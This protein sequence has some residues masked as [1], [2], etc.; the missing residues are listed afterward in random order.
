MHILRFFAVDSYATGSCCERRCFCDTAGADDEGGAQKDLNKMCS[1][2]TP[3]SSCPSTEGF[4]E[5]AWNWDKVDFT[6]ANTHD[7]CA[8]FDNNDNGMAD[9][10][11][12]AS[13]G[14]SD[15]TVVDATLLLYTCRDD[16]PDRCQDA[17]IVGCQFVT[18]TNYDP[19]NGDCSENPFLSSTLE[20]LLRK[21]PEE[22]DTYSC[23]DK[24]TGHTKNSNGDTGC[25]SG[26]DPKGFD[27]IANIC[28]S[29]TDVPASAKLIDVCSYPSV[30]PNSDPSDCVVFT[31]CDMI[32]CPS[33]RCFQ[34]SCD[35]ARGRCVQDTS[36]ADAV[37]NDGVKCTLDTCEVFCD[38]NGC[39]EVPN[40]DVN[41]C[42]SFGRE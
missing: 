37:C 20:V 14:G 23:T 41:G 2:I 3:S 1:L 24:S 22:G 36:Q 7:A 29:T 19:T 17:Q 15:R 21:G 4:Q 16:R 18:D 5:I 6:G 26:N 27:Q 39:N 13:L 30:N 11:L 34:Q 31:S 40:L 28:V 35:P 8:L 25:E 9:F 33:D 38:S 12:C 42:R 10:A 32:Q